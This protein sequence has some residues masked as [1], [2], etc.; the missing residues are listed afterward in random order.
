[1]FKWLRH[2]TKRFLA[3]S[4]IE[5]NALENSPMEWR[6]AI[7]TISSPAAIDVTT[8]ETV[9]SSEITVDILGTES[10]YVF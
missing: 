9:A 7:E 3:G 1:M 10:A 2:H 6:L 5:E 4:E 8:N